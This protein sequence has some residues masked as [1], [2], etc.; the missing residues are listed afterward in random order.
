MFSAPPSGALVLGVPEVVGHLLLQRGLEH[1]RGDRL[2]QPLRAGD[3]LTPLPAALTSCAIAA[4]ANWLMR[5][6]AVA[7]MG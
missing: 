6:R 5:A 7:L 2:Q 4:S 3:V 1:G